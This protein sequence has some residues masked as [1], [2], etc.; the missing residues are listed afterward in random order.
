MTNLDTSEMT[1]NASDTITINSEPRGFRGLPEL[2][3]RLGVEPGIGP[4]EFG[5]VGDDGQHYDIMRMLHALLDRI[6]DVEGG[7]G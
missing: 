5:L 1:M 2:A 6:E 3:R 4:G 7:E